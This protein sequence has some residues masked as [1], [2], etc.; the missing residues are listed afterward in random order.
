MKSLLKLSLQ[1]SFLLIAIS[2]F[3]GCEKDIPDDPTTHK[4]DTVFVTDTVFIIDTVFI[5][6]KEEISNYTIYGKVQKGPFRTGSTITVSELT[7]KFVPTGKNFYST[8]S[9]NFGK[10]K[11]PNVELESDYVEI[12]ADGNFYHETFGI[13][14]DTRYILKALANL[15][16]STTVNVNLLTHLTFDR[17]K[18]LIFNEGKSFQ[19]AK[20]QAQNELLKVF[21]LEEDNPVN[22]DFLDISQGG[23]MNSKLFA[24][25]IIVLGWKNYGGISEFLTSFAFDFETDGT[26]DNEDIQKSLIT[27]ALFCNTGGVRYNMIKLYEV[28][29]F[30]DF[31]IYVNEF[32]E[33]TSFLPYANFKFEEETESGV[34]LL[35][36]PD[37]STLSTDKTYCINQNLGFK[38]MNK[39]FCVTILEYEGHGNVEYIENDVSTWEY[40][41][42]YSSNEPDLGKIVSG[43][44][45]RPHLESDYSN[46]P[47]SLKF[48]GS[49]LIKL[50]IYY[51]DRAALPDNGGLHVVVRYLK[52]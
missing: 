25:S 40:S 38:G 14:T 16:D 31:Q 13:I 4:T 20:L 11:V 44:S 2:V 32:I 7:D 18:Y 37:N 29:D 50:S 35:A 24:I 21:N 1:L 5:S 52:W 45:L 17:I 42:D 8:V 19:D 28:N 30:P 46:T 39:D 10:F 26:I 49:G 12:Q 34:N 6:G 43:I 9:D 23:E 3:I 15:K 22:C 33:K 36:L 41:T 48:K 27:S 47:V 51:Q